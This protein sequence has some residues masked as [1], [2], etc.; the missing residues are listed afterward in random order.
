LLIS[1]DLIINYVLL[2]NIFSAVSLSSVALSRP[3]LV[4]SSILLAISFFNFLAFFF[5][6]FLLF[7]PESGANNIPANAPAAAQTNAATINPG[8]SCFFINL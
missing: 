1:S 3:L 2:F 8:V 7:F 6:F 4:T 5:N